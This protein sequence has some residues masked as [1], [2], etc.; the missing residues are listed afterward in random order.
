MSATADAATTPIST[1]AVDAAL[2]SG[3][4]P[5]RPSALSAC[6]TYG[7]RGMLKIRHMP[8]QLID[9]TIGP[10][11]L[12]VSFTYLFGGAIAG[13]TDDYLQFLLP[14]IL[15]LAVLFTAIYSGATLN[16]DMTTHVVDRFRSLPVWPPAPLVGAVL[17]DTVR[18]ALT[19][20]I[21]VVFGIVLG[22][23]A[24]GVAGVVGAVLLVVVFAFS[25]SWVFTTA[26]LVL[27]SPSAVQG[28][29]MTG[30]FS[31]VFMSNVFVD[32]DTM[33]RV[34]EA[35][36]TVNPISHLVTAVRGLLAGAGSAADIALV[37]GE[38]GVIT[39]VFAPLTARLYGKG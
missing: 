2:A 39:A 12:L 4:R 31:L 36:V 37:L 8:E 29:G 16:T 14:G 23:E 25:L 19:G 21:V 9:V 30:I 13:S 32:P 38:A 1:P 20:A 3:I 34:L 11:L 18:Y 35:F 27:R 5:P 7:W 15:V 24:Q 22:F 33:P 6:V 10:V 17:G 26:G 28:A